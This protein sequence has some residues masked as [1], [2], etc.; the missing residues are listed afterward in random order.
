MLKEYFL[1]IFTGCFELRYFQCFN[2]TISD[3]AV[4]WLSSLRKDWVHPEDN[5]V[6]M[7]DG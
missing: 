7:M 4:G 6:A 1:Q 3:I 2:R 5:R